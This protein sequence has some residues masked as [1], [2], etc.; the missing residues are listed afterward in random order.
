VEINPEGFIL[1]YTI[2]IPVDK[3]NDGSPHWKD[4]ELVFEKKDLIPEIQSLFILS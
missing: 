4:A 2:P 3:N 1:D